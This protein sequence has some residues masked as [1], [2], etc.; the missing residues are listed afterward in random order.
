[1]TNKNN[2]RHYRLTAALASWQR[3]LNG[4]L[5][6]NGQ[7]QLTLSSRPERSGVERSAVSHFRLK[8]V[9]VSKDEHHYYVYIVASRA[10]PRLTNAIAWCGSSITSM[11]TTPINREKQIKHWSRAKKV[12]LIEQA[13]PTWADLS[14]EWK[15]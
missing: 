14:E 12:W 4:Q 3:Y 15:E 8:G 9:G 7:L 1:M 11:S 13:N 2:S 10:S 5:H 6:L